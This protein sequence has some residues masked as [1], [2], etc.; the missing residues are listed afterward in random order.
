LK[1]SAPAGRGSRARPGQGVEGPEDLRG[2]ER[3]ARV[4]QQQRPRRDA[5]PGLDP[6][7]HAADQGGARV[8]EVGHV[9]SEPQGEGGQRLGRERARCK[10]GEPPQNRSGVARAAA[11]TGRGGNALGEAQPNAP[12]QT[13]RGEEALR[14]PHRE[15]RGVGRHAVCEAR[16]LA[17]QRQLDARVLLFGAELQLHVVREVE[18]QE[19]A[20]ELVVAIRAAPEHAQ[21]PIDLG[22]R[23]EPSGARGSG[24]GARRHGPPYPAPR[25][26]STKR[27][28][29]S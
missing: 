23:G 4:H 24:R 2:R 15:V 22:G 14:G 6:L 3:E 20:L 27:M 13:R 21:V 29:T 18:G 10:G 7:P 8:Q 25:P 19:E 16:R 11:E 1:G 26:T 9:G 12:A 5:A 17:R 28:R